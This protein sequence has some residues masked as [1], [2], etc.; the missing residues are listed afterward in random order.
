[1]SDQLKQEE[2]QN[3]PAWKHHLWQITPVQDVFWF[4]LAVFAIWSGYV[5]RGILIPMLIAFAAAYTV[6]PLLQYAE[7]R[8]DIRRSVLISASLF[9]L[10]VGCC[11]A[12][13]ALAPPL[14]KQADDLMTKTPEYLTTITN[15][16]EGKV[17][18][19][20]IERFGLSQ[21]AASANA[22]DIAEAVV[23]RSGQAISI[24]GN[25][26]GST[27]YIVAA[28]ALLPIYFAYFAWNFQPLIDRAK[29]WIPDRNKDFILHLFHRMDKAVGNFIRGRLLI[30]CMMMVLF[31]IAFWI[32]G[33]PYWFL[34]GAATGLLSFIPYLA[35][36]G[37]GLAVLI[38]WI[39]A[40]TGGNDVTLVAVVVWPVA[41]YCVVQLLEGWLLTPWIQSQSMEMSAVAVLVVLMIGGSLAGIYGLLLAIP[42]AGCLKILAE[43]LVVPKLDKWATDAAQ[44]TND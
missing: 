17:G 12:V 9:L 25:V 36:V 8:W 30:V 39:D 40:T 14:L 15:K 19:E 10:A 24:L 18:R 13:I 7:R 32:A 26:L 33:V 1:M 3:R 28:L 35:V 23:G 38:T 34:I 42:I 21:A 22:P 6:N 20:W 37:C 4:S 41:A 31:S 29:S 43:E 16:L 44:S 11:L 5:L 27:A 2:D